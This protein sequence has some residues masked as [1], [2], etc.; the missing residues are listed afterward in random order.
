MGPGCHCGPRVEHLHPSQIGGVVQT[1]AQGTSV[2]T[3]GTHDIGV[4]LDALSLMTTPLAPMGTQA[5]SWRKWQE[6]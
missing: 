1:G 6:A 3:K 2:V 4:S 5:S